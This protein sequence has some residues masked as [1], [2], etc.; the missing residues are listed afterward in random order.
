M[1]DDDLFNGMSDDSLESL[2]H[3]IFTK[4]VAT[5]ETFVTPERLPT[6][7]HGT[8]CHSQ[9]VYY[10]IMVWMGMRNTMKTTEWGWKQEKYQLIQKPLFEIIQ[11]N[12][13]VGYNS[14]RCICR[15]YRI[16]CTAACGP[17]QTENFDNP[18]NFREVC[19]EDEEDDTDS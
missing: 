1:L 12:C 2:R 13:S 7:S 10:Q 19:T 4:Y 11:C 14:Y 16:P 15:R 18:N 9:R 8:L 17:C 5:V 6:T 3:N